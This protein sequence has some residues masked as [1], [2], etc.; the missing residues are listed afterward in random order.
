MSYES[1]PY[2]LAHEE[3]DA[4]MSY[5]SMPSPS[6]ITGRRSGVGRGVGE[7]RVGFSV[8]VR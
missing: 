2:H 3:E 5:E 7:E 6:S 4:C 8:V 1:K